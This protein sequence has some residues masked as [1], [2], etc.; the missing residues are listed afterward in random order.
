MDEMVRCAQRGWDILLRAA[1]PLL[2]GGVVWAGLNAIT[3]GL[4]T[5][6]ALV[7]LFIVALK[8]HQGKTTDV[9]VS[10][11]L[12]SGPAVRSMIRWISVRHPPQPPPALQ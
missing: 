12:A 8:T 2:I 11:A 7:G 5:G 9:G 3:A 1:V 6:P 4:L 10:D